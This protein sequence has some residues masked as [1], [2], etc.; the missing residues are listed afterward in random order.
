SASIKPV[1]N[2]DG[3]A[4]IRYPARGNTVGDGHKVRAASGEQNAEVLHTTSLFTTEAQRYG[5]NRG[6]SCPPERSEGSAVR[7]KIQI[8]RSGQFIERVCCA[9]RSE[10]RA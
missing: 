1:R 7:R 6:S 10:H 8:P 5:E 4:G 2:H 9:S 3:D